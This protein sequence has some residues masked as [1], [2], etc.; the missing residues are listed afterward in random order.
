MQ[1]ERKAPWM[2]Y[3]PEPNP[4]LVIV[5][6]DVNQIYGYIRPAPAEEFM[7]LRFDQTVLQVAQ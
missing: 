5:H 2:Q 6:N 3:S 7:D 4:H 1:G